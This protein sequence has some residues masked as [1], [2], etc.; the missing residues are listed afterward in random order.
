[1]ASG[2]VRGSKWVHVGGPRTFRYNTDRKAA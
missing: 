2:I 1:M